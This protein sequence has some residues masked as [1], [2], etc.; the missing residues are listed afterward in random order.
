MFDN[1]WAKHS[2][3]FENTVL[4]CDLLAAEETGRCHRLLQKHVLLWYQ[5]SVL[6]LRSQLWLLFGRCLAGGKSAWKSFFTCFGCNLLGGSHGKCENSTWD[7][8]K[9]IDPATFSVHFGNHSIMVT[10]A[11]GSCRNISGMGW[12]LAGG[13]A[14]L[15]I[16][17][18]QRH[19]RY[20][21]CQGLG[22]HP[23]ADVNLGQVGDRNPCYGHHGHWWSMIHQ[24]HNDSI[25][26]W[27]TQSEVPEI[28]R[29]HQQYTNHLDAL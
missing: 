15:S 2:N 22:S 18:A 25:I 19:E 13:W 21:I 11:A 8:L 10:D 16:D 17:R 1:I 23:W 4:Y 29:W 3:I 26:F 28:E 12:Q 5:M 6:A 27:Q 14:T 7:E 24:E 9:M 20:G